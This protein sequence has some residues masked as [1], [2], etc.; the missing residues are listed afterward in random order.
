MLL[1]LASVAVGVLEPQ[2][3]G[4]Q[5]GFIIS[6]IGITAIVSGVHAM[7]RARWG[8]SVARAFGRGG[9]ILGSVGTGLMAYAVLASGLTSVGVELPALS[10]PVDSGAA[11]L[12]PGILVP[13]AASEATSAPASPAPQA[14]PQAVAP[15]DGLAD[16]RPEPQA[17]VA[18]SVVPATLAAERAQL[19]QSLG[20]LDFVMRQS[21]G[22]GQYPQSLGIGANAP[23]RILTA[24]GRGLA[25]VPDGT[26][27]LYSVAPDGSSWSATLVGSRF[28]A[29]ATFSSATGSLVAG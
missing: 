29:V 3:A 6:T 20:T 17:D 11:V 5:S 10:L 27:L 2:R 26:R 15:A 19:T 18:T 16:G 14:A 23:Q 21:F 25:A 9:A 8:S 22:P 28:G 4:L 12:S 13:Q 1:G 24:D 7:K